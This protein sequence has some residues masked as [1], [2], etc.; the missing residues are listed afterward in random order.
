MA[1]SPGAGKTEAS[2]ELL[3]ALGA[4]AI[5]IDADE[6]RAECPG[7]NGLNAWLYQRAA[8]I[9][10]NKLQDVALEQS[11]SFVLDGTFS[12]IDLARQNVE[13]SIKR[14][15]LI[16]I[17]YVYQEP[18]LAW[19]FVQDR[20][21]TEGRRV[22]PEHFVRQYFSARTVVNAIKAEFGVAVKVD[23]LVKNVDNS[24]RNF[25]FGVEQI[26]PYIPERYSKADVERIVNPD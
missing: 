19:K 26:D 15:R 3:S 7:Y 8:V 9:L 10:V 25:H 16:Q 17:L 13:R 1:G 21:A 4:S 23:V 20:E 24:N 5:R 22:N 6:L 12:N 11:Q 14:K 2:I 18:A